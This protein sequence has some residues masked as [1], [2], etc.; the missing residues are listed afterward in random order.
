M[1]VS[2]IVAKD[3]NNLI[4]I[5]QEMPWH[6]PKDFSY[7]KETTTGHPIIMGRKTFESIGCRPLPNRPHVIVT[8]DYTLSYK[9]DNVVTVSSVEDAIL[10]AKSFE[11]ADTSEV[12]ICGGGQIYAYALNHN[13]I[14][15]IYA[16]EIHTKIKVDEWDQDKCIYFPQF[17]NDA[18]DLTSIKTYD[19]DEKNKYNMT[20][21]VF[22]RN[23]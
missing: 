6:L 13:L 12:F 7:F 3:Q 8:T 11:H 5:G 17:G 22:E 10:I 19:A 15:K 9:S 23:Y 14:D 4:G 2:A 18:W 1:I 20:F 16:T 21:M